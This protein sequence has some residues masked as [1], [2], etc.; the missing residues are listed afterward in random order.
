MCIETKLS[1]SVV[2]D[3]DEG[4]D[5]VKGDRDVNKDVV[6]CA[7]IVR[8]IEGNLMIDGEVNNDGDE[9]GNGVDRDDDALFNL[10]IVD[11]KCLKYLPP[12]MTFCLLFSSV[13][14]A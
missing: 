3:D 7:L 11:S 2:L 9:D 5:D 6:G 10:N 8:S 14:T 4:I 12:F 1:Q 13:H